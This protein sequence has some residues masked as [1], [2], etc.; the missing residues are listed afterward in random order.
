MMISDIVN[1]N[2]NIKNVNIENDVEYS[3]A[4]LDSR[5]VTKNS[6]FFGVKG[7]NADGN[8]Y[9]DEALKKG[10]SLV[11]LDNEDCYSNTKGNKILVD[12]TLSFMKDFGKIALN[13]FKGIKIA[14]TGSFG[15]TGTKEILK[16][17]FNKKYS[18]YGTEG[19]KNNLLGVSL[20]ACGI[21]NSNIGIFEIGSNGLGEIE[22]L[23]NLINPDIAIVTSVGHAHVGRFNGIEN[24]KK[25]K[26]SIEKGLKDNGTLII[27]YYLKDYVISSKNI[28]T[29]GID[30][31]A[32]I[33]LKDI[34]HFGDYITFNINN[35]NK[36]YKLNH[37]YIHI[38]EQVLPVIASCKLCDIDED[39]II[40][41]INDYKPIKG[42]GNIEKVNNITI[43]DDTYNAGFEAILR[44]AESLNMINVAPKYAIYGETG[45]IEGYEF[46]I[47][48][49]IINLSEKY[50]DINFIFIGKEYLKYKSSSNCLIYED[51]IGAYNYINSIKNGII[52]V[53]A[54]RSKKFEDII[55]VI[56]ME[57]DNAL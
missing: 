46:E 15:K 1:I 47:Y 14:V 6:I 53:K 2:T 39:T 37:P 57:K 43:I 28:I 36:L 7:E 55:N 4:Y 5:L 23:S 12:D 13:N 8:R 25:E 10:A 34:K 26:I 40:E 44:S 45:E 49:E 20:T 56:K 32:D 29:F 21:D 31:N 19:N 18:V 17:V 9:S 51:K 33:Y 11:V 38:A 42:R 27:P 54:S 30:D 16:K 50:K 41:A 35:S 52:L 48:K 22:T 3:G 24:I